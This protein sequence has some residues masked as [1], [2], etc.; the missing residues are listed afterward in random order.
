MRRDVN[1]IANMFPKTEKSHHVINPLS[2][3][4]GVAHTAVIKLR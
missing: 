3:V 2:L 1:K 4:F